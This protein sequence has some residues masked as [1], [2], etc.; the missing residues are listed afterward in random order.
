MP[1]LV[2]VPWP[3]IRQA[4]G[5]RP[6][7]YG[8]DELLVVRLNAAREL[9]ILERWPDVIFRETREHAV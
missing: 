4:W 2:S 1:V 9:S 5:V 3:V 6:S 7:L 8:Y